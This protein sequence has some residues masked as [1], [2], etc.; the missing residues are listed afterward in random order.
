MSDY[1]PDEQ[2]PLFQASKKS[3]TTWA[4]FAKAVSEMRRLQRLYFTTRERDTLDQAKRHEATVDQMIHEYEKGEAI[5]E[6]RAHR[7]A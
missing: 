4:E 2:L 3:P 6:T 5:R 1:Y 7:P